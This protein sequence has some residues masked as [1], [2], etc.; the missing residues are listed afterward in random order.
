MPTVLNFD[1]NRLPGVL[2]QV[3]ELQAKLALDPTQFQALLDTLPVAVLF[4]LDR[5]CHQ[6][7]GNAAARVLL[8]ALP[9]QNLSRSANPRELPPFTVFVDG[10]PVAPDD[11]PMQKAARTGRP[12]PRS[13]CE[14]RFPDGSHIFLEGHSVPLLDKAGAVCG[15]IG[16]FVDISAVKRLESENRALTAQLEQ[17]SAAPPRPATT[18]V[19]APVLAPAL[20]P[21]LAA[22]P[23]PLAPPAPARFFDGISIKAV[24]AMIVGAAVLPLTLAMMWALFTLN[25][26]ADARQRAD[27]LYAARSISS[28]VDAELG[29]YV[30]LAEGLGRAPSLR[31]DD[32]AAFRAE[33]A[34]MFPSSATAWV[35]VSDLDGQ[36]L[37]NTRITD[38]SPLPRRLP[39]AVA[40]QRRAL[41]LG[42]TLVSDVT[43]GTS[44]GRPLVNIEVPVLRDGKPFRALTLAIAAS[45]FN[46]LLHP[47]DTPDSWLLGVMDNNGRYVARA[48]RSEELIGELA[49]DNWRKTAGQDGLFEFASRD[50]DLMINANRRM[51]R[52]GWTIGVAIKKKEFETPAARSFNLGAAA[53]GLSLALSL[54]LAAALSRRVAGAITGLRDNASA[55]LAGGAS[56]TLAAPRLPEL[57]ETWRRLTEAVA[58]RDRHER[59]LHDK[60]QQ[61]ETLLE[62]A[63]IGIAYFDRQHRYVQ[64][65]AELAEINGIAVQ[66]HIGRPIE[67]LLPR[68]AALVG[69]IL[70]GVFANGRV[71]RS[72]EIE[73]ETPNQPGVTRYWL[74]GFFPVR[75]NFGRVDLVGA[76]VV[77]ITDRKRVEEQ[78]RLLM[79]EVNHRSKNLLAVVQAIAHQ[80]A[81]KHDP[82]TFMTRFSQRLRSLAANQ[83][84]LIRSESKAVD[85]ADLVQA[86]LAPFAESIGSRIA[87]AGDKVSVAS[88][89]SQALGL[90]LHELATN[91][92]KHGALSR[93]AGRVEIA[94][95]HEGADFVMQWVERDGP[96][97]TPPTHRGFG[98][99]VTTAMVERSLR[100]QASLSFAPEGLTW[101]LRCPAANLSDPAED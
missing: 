54:L 23:A 19:V 35:V 15:S 79:R 12:V 36:Q 20:A 7:D 64:V 53:I 58:A 87:Y 95:H 32:L 16:A 65:N 82:Q 8:R 59:A 67:D 14:V 100:G 61:L 90:A 39:Q 43:T 98:T 63:P 31:D 93:E 66:D 29:K 46:A 9:G 13:E 81:R 92:T 75:D 56:A 94:W 30:A 25:D 88:N 17:Q 74:C 22:E 73:G 10:A 55:L 47:A 50:G 78:N 68:N 34:R 48:P 28:S 71:T 52:T 101:R 83:D 21:G 27:L 3:I 80:V 11:L 38:G 44:T 49:S 51:E 60:T 1:R 84:L 41:A 2:S 40:Y 91:A 97:V 77:E 42:R 76:W 72:I 45:N 69:P 4:S 86:Q 6:M 57:R 37:L 18:P 99:T 5:E 70:D 96:P 33:A 24:L 26:L 62:S 85:L 89:A